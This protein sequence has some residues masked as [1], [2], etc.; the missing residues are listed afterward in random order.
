MTP[1]FWLLLSLSALGLWAIFSLTCCAVD[2][3]QSRL[4]RKTDPAYDAFERVRLDLFVRN[5]GQ[6]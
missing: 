5:G 2:W 3:C 1:T 6:Q 4:L